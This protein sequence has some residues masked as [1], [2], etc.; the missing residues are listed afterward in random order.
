MPIPRRAIAVPRARAASR[1]F[2]ST[3]PLDPANTQTRIMAFLYQNSCHKK[4]LREAQRRPIGGAWQGG[5]MTITRRELLAGAALLPAARALAWVPERPRPRDVAD[6]ALLAAMQAGATYADV[7]LVRQRRQNLATRDDHLTSISD[8]ESYGLGVRVLKAGTWG[9]AAA[10]EITAGSASALARKAVQ[11]AEANAALERRPVQLAPEPPHEDSWEAPIEKDPLRVPVKTKVALL[12]E[13][14][15]AAVPQVRAVMGFFRL[16][17]EEKAFFSSEGSAIEQ[18]IT[19]TGG[20]YTVT[21]VEEG[22]GFETRRTLLP[23]RGAGFEHVERAGFVEQ[24]PRIAREALDKLR[25][26]RVKPGPRD[27]VLDPS[28]LWLTIH[29]SLGHSTELDRVLGYEANF[30]GTSFATADQLGKLRYGGPLM[31]VT[32]DRVEPGGLATCGYDDDGVAT[33][34]FDLIREGVLVAF[35]TVRDQTGL[36][37]FGGPRSSGCSYADSW[38]SVPF[39]RMP[40]VSLM[41]GKAPLTFDEL[42]TQTQDGI[43]IVGDG[44]YS[45]DHQRKNFQ[46]G[47]DF[48]W[49]IANGKLARPLRKVAYQSNTP[50]FW[51]SMDAVCDAREWRLYGAF[52]DAKGEP[53]QLN[54]VSHGCPPAR[55]RGVR[56]IDA[57]AVQS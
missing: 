25:A 46:F 16:A 45:I 39:Q 47:G 55:F 12:V 26:D 19:R 49:Q 15:K 51:S 14:A 24:A 5:D 42:I 2:T 38:A 11:I 36:P 44:S 33:Q 8:T 28:H 43:Y 1:Y 50:E 6:A 57:G 20:G 54:P 7:R 21:A 32:A 18:M 52:D 40:N 27:L 48:F 53:V 34:R 9:F 29:E 30:A 35:Q 56:V 17:I 10:P 3:D 37:G 4:A 13:A 31:H 41:A 23:P 22:R